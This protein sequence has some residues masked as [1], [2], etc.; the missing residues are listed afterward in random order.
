MCILKFRFVSKF[1]NIFVLDQLSYNIYSGY[2]F[3]ILK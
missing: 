2:N 3:C 1:H